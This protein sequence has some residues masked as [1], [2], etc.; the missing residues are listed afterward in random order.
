MK[1]LVLNAG[2]S[3]LKCS[4][5]EV[6]GQSPLETPPALWEGEIGGARLRVKTSA[7]VTLETQ[8]P[9][10]LIE[11]SLTPLLQTLWSDE[12]AVVSGPHEIAVV[13]HR[14]VEGGVH[15][16]SMRVTQEVKAEIERCVSLAPS[17][18]PA[19]LG[20]IETI[21]KMW[22]DIQQIAVF[23]TAFGA[24]L[25]DAA[26][27]YPGPYAWAE[28]GL[29]RTGFHGIS[30][31]DCAARTAE[32]LGRG[33]DSL[34][35]IS[36]HLGNGCS[37]SAIENGKCVDTTMGFTPLEG[38]MMGTRSGSVD[39]GLL[40]YL[41]RGGMSADELEQILTRESGLKGISGVS[42]DLR[43]VLAARAQ[44]NDH[45]ALAFDIYVHRLRGGIGSMLAS[46]GGLDALVFTGG[47]GQNNALVRAAACEN[48]KFLG[49]RIASAKNE[50][51]PA[52]TDISDCDSTV[53]ILVLPAQE[54][55]AIARECVAVMGDG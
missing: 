2:S 12:T 24:D 11:E 17:H 40:L 33:L 49:L 29:R 28:Q 50:A 37:L 1:I 52:K 15:R 5:F 36:C 4:L 27:I 9:T 55:W 32:I 19:A 18:N 34:R 35:L 38:L 45:A 48:F 44:G 16:Q 41:L 20:G 39:P 13:G 26:A 53:R 31:A 6:A 10:D 23:D 30:H 21:E 43:E 3:N 51:T 22:G 7:G 46:L 42:G 8:L 14:V 54:N 47:V 25:P